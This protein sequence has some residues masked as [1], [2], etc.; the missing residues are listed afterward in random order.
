MWV[1]ACKNQTD[2]FTVAQPTLT[3]TFSLASPLPENGAMFA[4]CQHEQQEDQLHFWNC[5]HR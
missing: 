3:V 5:T 2:I 1:S 4:G